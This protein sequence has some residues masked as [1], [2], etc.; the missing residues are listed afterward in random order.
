MALA[1]YTNLISSLNDWLGR[2]D[3]SGTIADDLIRI[4]EEELYDILRVPEMEKRYRL[5][6]ASEFTTLPDDFLEGRELKV[7]GTTKRPVRYRTP[8]A[9]DNLMSRGISGNEVYFTIRGTELQMSGYPA[10]VASQTVS[11]ATS[12]GTTVTITTASDHGLSAGDSITVTDSNS[13]GYEIDQALVVSVPSATT[14]TYTSDSTPTASPATG[15]IAYAV[16]NVELTYYYKVDGLSSSNQTNVLLTNYPQLYLFGCLK[17]A[18]AYVEDA[19]ILEG[20][21]NKFETRA[22]MANVRAFNREFSGSQL[23]MIADKGY[24]DGE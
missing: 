19:D 18:G 16:H 15:T 9:I 23:E 7:I 3:L 8:Q 5:Q 6:V 1:N 12:V 14:F 4:C 10:I 13:E 2:S 24:Y 20:Y 21:R 11:S 22:E 17:E